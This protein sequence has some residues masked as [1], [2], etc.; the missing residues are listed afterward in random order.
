MMRALAIPVVL[1]HGKNISPWSVEHRLARPGTIHTGTQISLEY[2]GPV[3]RMQLKLIIAVFYS[4][5]C[6]TG[7]PLK[8][9][10]SNITACPLVF[11][12]D[13]LQLGGDVYQLLLKIL[14]AV[15][16]VYCVYNLLDYSCMQCWHIFKYL[17]FR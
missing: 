4:M 5:C 9:L 2:E 16:I 7:T 14:Y 1:V 10:S 11:S 13:K 17:Y 12:G 15:H 6:V 3:L 8:T